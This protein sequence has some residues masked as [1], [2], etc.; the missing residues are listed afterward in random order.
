MTKRLRDLVVSPDFDWTKVRVVR[1]YAS[2]Y[3]AAGALDGEH[4]VALD[5]M[6][7]DNV[8]SPNPTYAM[9]GYSVYNDGST[10]S[11]KPIYK[12]ANTSNYIEFRANLGVI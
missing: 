11:P 8:S 3:D 4:Y 6:R 10:S 2:C 12:V 5:G 1:I 9:T 7:F